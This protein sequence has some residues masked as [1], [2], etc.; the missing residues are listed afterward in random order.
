MTIAVASGKG[1]TGKTF[2]ATNLFTMMELAGFDVALADCDVEVPDCSIFVKKTP[3][4]TWTTTI[5]TPKTDISKCV[6]CGDCADICNYNAITCVAA[7]RYLTVAPEL[8]HSCK[9]CLYA[10]QHEAIRAAQTEVG[11]VV[12]YG[13]GNGSNFFVGKLNEGQNSAVPVIADTMRRCGDLH[14][15]YTIVDAPPGCTCPFVHV[16]TYSDLI[17]LVGEPTPFGLSDLRHTID[18]LRQIE[19]PFWVVIN[20]SDLGFGELRTFLDRERIPVC[21]E[22]P[23]SETLAKCCARGE[24][25]V[26]TEPTTTEVFRNLMKKIVEYENCDCQRQRR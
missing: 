9:A 26:P 13:N 11:T 10:C 2:V 5:F 8:C 6:F 3:Q 4:Q 22:I 15:R 24:T 7:A 16:V 12:A 14:R 18:V 25:A 19:K 21:A 17:I 23:Y 1:G 20:K